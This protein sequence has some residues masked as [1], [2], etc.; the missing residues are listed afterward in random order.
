MATKTLLTIGQNSAL[1]E[2]VGVRY[3]LDRGELIVTSSPA[4]MHNII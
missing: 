2:P 3:E 4:P 1:E